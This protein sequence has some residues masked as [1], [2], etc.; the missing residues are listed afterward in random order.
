MD[1]EALRRREQHS[2]GHRSEP[3]TTD[4]DP[5]NTVLYYLYSHSIVP[6][7]LDVTS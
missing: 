6:G 5:A 3:E 7:G 4:T 1:H 2:Q